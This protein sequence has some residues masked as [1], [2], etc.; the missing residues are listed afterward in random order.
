MG[1]LG[2]GLGA[3]WSTCTN[4]G[5]GGF[6]SAAHS[7]NYYESAVGAFPSLHIAAPRPYPGHLAVLASG[8]PESTLHAGYH[9]TGEG[10]VGLHELHDTNSVRSTAALGGD[11]EEGDE[12]DTGDDEEEGDDDEEAR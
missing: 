6:G 5:A 11:E 3:Q 2:A 12:E 7:A 9:E 8:P 10:D 4:N 1:P